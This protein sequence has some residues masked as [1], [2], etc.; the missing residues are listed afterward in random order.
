MKILKWFFFL[1]VIFMNFKSNAQQ[2]KDILGIA[3]EQKDLQYYQ[4]QRELWKEKI[5]SNSKNAKAW[6]N[7]Y[8]AN[9]AI[10]QKEDYKLWLNSREEIFKNLNPILEKLNKSLPNSY[11]YYWL[12]S[13][14]TTNKEQAFKLASKAYDIAPERKEV[15][16]ELFIYYMTRWQTDK[17]A[18]IADKILKANCYTNAL[19]QWNLNSLNVANSKSV[20]ITHGDL[21]TLP[22]WV[23]QEALSIRKDVLIVNEWLMVDSDEYRKGVFFKLNINPFDK[24]VSDFENKEVYKN[25]LLSYMIEQVGKTKSIYF[26]CGTDVKLFD[27]LNIKE[28]MYLTGVSFVYSHQV[29][30]NLKV[31]KYNFEEVLHLD[32]LFAD[33]QNHP[34]S[35]MVKKTLN[36]SYI[37]SLMKLKKYYISVNNQKKIEKCDVIITRILDDSGRKKEIL[38]WYE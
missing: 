1:G 5:D 18:I 37:P 35:E 13:I 21:D 20:L 19:Y 17:A 22:R 24:L 4:K 14:N 38:S 16:E 12:S 29:I 7:Y 2:A 34:Q 9:R 26:D 36:I 33:F 27:V 31:T 6:I 10:S 30:D 8:K 25:R 23:L 32:Y 15:Y 11:E 28:K 3:N